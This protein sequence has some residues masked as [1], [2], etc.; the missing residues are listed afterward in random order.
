MTKS[1]L[2]LSN[3]RAVVIVVVLAFHS[4]LA[5]IASA[6]QPTRFDQPPYTWEAFPI[7]DSQHWLGFDIFCA[8]QDV[9]LMA[10]MFFLSGLLAGPSLARKGAGVYMLNRLRR[11]G[12]PFAFA[13]L[14]L[15]PLALYPAYAVRTPDPS[16][17]GYAKEWFALP[18][19][20]GG[21]QW[22]LWQLVAINGIAAALYAL[23]PSMLRDFRRIGAWAGSHARDHYI[24]LSA[25]CILGYVPLA[26]L[27]SPFNW[28]EFGPFGLQYCRPLLYI[29][30][31]FAG[32]S[33]GSYGLDRGLL[34]TDGALARH[35]RAWITLAVV[36]FC[37]WAGLTSLTFPD[38]DQASFAGQIGASL[39]FPPACVA[40]GLALLSVFLRF[41]RMRSR[42]LDS[43][44]VN[45]YG[46]YLVHYVF[47][48]W[49]QYALM[50]AGLPAV[51]KAALV[52]IGSVAFSWPAGILA[53][54][55][56]TGSVVLRSKRPALTLSR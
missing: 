45:A 41:S 16:L 4:F 36:T 14:F 51:A 24:L 55:L 6:P 30:V 33:L 21:P 44:S 13:V 9:S 32:F 42:I 53:T 7:V 28:V 23:S 27:F 49:L 52:F 15:S 11:I 17:A 37:I 47:T 1:S 48:V 50:P 35:W 8:W 10:L 2:A 40:G 19:W 54:K 39:S 20:P 56:L 46:I 26:L 12:V 18:Y 22:F 29:A 5:Y 31:F 34:A 38:W 43:L 25:I 3:L